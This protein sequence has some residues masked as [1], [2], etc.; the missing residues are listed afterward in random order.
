MPSDFRADIQGLRA[1]AVLAVLLYHAHLPLLPGGYIGVD[2]FFV[3]SGF[4]ITGHLLAQHERTGRIALGMFYARRARRI[5]PASLVVLA[6]SVLA[7]LL[8]FPPV[9]F[10]DLWESAIA[11]A[12]YVPNLYFAR[13]GTDY[14]AESAPSLLQHYWSLGIEEQFYLLWPLVL[15]LLL[16]VTRGR[17]AVA[18]GTL[19]LVVGSLT[20]CLVLTSSNQPWAFFSLPTRAWE[21]GLG[22]LVALVGSR[23]VPRG[24]LGSL[25]GWCGLAAILASAVVFD[26]DTLFPGAAALVPTLGTALVIWAGHCPSRI[27]PTAL[28]GLAPMQWLGLISYSLYL[29]HWPLQVL[30]Q[31]WVGWENPL[32]LSATLA[33]TLAAVPVAW[34]LY[35]GV[36][37]PV[38]R[39][40]ALI[41]ARPRR[42]LLAAGAGSLSVIVLAT[43][44]YALT[45]LDPL[46]VPEAAAAHDW[47]QEPV[48]TQVVP[49][50]M[51]PS[52][53]EVARS[54]PLIYDDGC[55]LDQ[56]AAQAQDCTY[57]EGEQGRIALFGDSHAAQWFPAL[58]EA[59]LA[60]G[61]AVEVYT[62]SACPSVR[63][64]V[65]RDNAPF[66]QCTQWREEAVE[67]LRA[68]PPD[69]TVVTNFARAPLAGEGTV[70][71]RWGGGL[72]DLL[73]DLPG[74]V[75]VLADTPYMAAT[76]AICL[77]LHTQDTDPCLRPREEALDPHVRDAEEEAAQ[78]AGARYVDLTPA[79]CTQVCPPVLGNT[80]VYRDAD[81]LTVPASEGLAPVLWEE[82]ALETD[83]PTS[84]AR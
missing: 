66:W 39:S 55:H 2:V 63:V 65:E 68:D 62:K 83:A 84:S 60:E 59:A 6:L 26:D 35:R 51:T 9:L 37:D 71:D 70:A 33:L 76:P 79:L 34:L 22:G 17:R 61:Y 57:G 25:L 11:T 30:P 69:L 3:I 43:G 67:R 73:A 82:L 28:L 40:R 74:R 64:E 44:A 41:A 10:R 31:A 75:V 8:W 46:S 18:L 12:L 27:G 47:H 14:L 56:D 15:I 53:R 19:A 29:V 23:G 13:E 81:H 7:A 16:R 72:E 45:R 36:E 58:H 80:L 78:A 4:L 77:S 20:L 38:R 48:A 5:L 50:N 42:V 21:L 1:V 52:I 49:S 32:P 54:R 24:R